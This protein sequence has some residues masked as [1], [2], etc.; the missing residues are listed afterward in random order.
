MQMQEDVGSMSPWASDNG[1]RG[2][3]LGEIY[4]TL[5]YKR[6][7]GGEALPLL[8]SGYT[9]VNDVTVN[10]TL[11][12]DIYDTAG[13]HITAVDV[14]YSYNTDIAE[15]NQASYTGNIAG[16]RA[17]DEY[18]V[19]L[20]IKTNGVGMME[21][22]L[23]LVR[24]VSQKAYESDR[25]NSVPVGT[26]PYVLKEWVTGSTVT[27]EKNDNYWNDN[28]RA[29]VAMANIDEI[30]YKVISESSQIMIAMETGEIDFT[31]GIALTDISHFLEGGDL[32]DRFNVYSEPSIL[33]QNLFFNCSDNNPFSD[34]RL[35]QAVCYALDN[36]AILDGAYDGLGS[37]CH[38]FGSELSSDY[39][40]SWKT[41]EYYEYNVARA[42]ELMKEAGYEQ[43]LDVVLL[44]DSLPAHVMMAQIIQLYL[45]EIGIN[46][47]INSY[48]SS[49]FNTYRFDPAQFD[50]HINNKAGGFVV[51]QWQYSL[52]ARLFN[53]ST[54]NWL[55]DEKWQSLYETAANA[56]THTPE[57]M[58]AAWQY[59][60]EI[61]PVYGIC[62]S[63][64]YYVGIKGID[65]FYINDLT[66]II[67]G[68]NTYSDD[69]GR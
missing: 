64:N 22:A 67:A 57:N 6:V 1:A 59:L 61:V 9:R 56:P 36:Q 47:K 66:Y 42:K 60:K 32:A 50:I 29:E 49:L 44:L 23:C 58:D 30:V 18:T 53:G 24:I 15:G 63:Y 11:H 39:L 33:S 19:E 10:V 46:V 5:C 37:V 69:F 21:D 27:L 52:D 38:A 34:V 3:V 62:F 16:I 41:E 14:V 7:L 2:I 43:G 12:N 8:A 31:S 17:L 54:T 13:N 55:V 4:E 40:D 65:E 45:G 51:Q 28:D 35:R 48:D 25:M 68:A 20:E 26:G